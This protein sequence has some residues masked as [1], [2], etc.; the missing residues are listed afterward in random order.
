MDTPKSD[1]VPALEHF[2]NSWASARKDIIMILCSSATYW[3]IS[4]IV[5]NRGGLYNRLTGRINL[6]PLTL[7]QCREFVQY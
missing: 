6:T 1:L 2:Y 3:V 5:H 7:A 4:R